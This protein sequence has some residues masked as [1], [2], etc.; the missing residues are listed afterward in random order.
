M[1]EA[2]RR[3]YGISLWTRRAALPLTI[4]GKLTHGGGVTL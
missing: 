3:F 1:G 2:F 4:A